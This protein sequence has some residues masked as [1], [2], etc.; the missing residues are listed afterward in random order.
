MKWHNLALIFLVGLL[1]IF[2]IFRLAKDDDSHK[3]KIRERVA[4]FNAQTPTSACRSAQLSRN[5]DQNFMNSCATYSSICSNP[6]TLTIVDNL[7]EGQED[8]YMAS[9]AYAVGIKP[10]DCGKL[11]Y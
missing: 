4:N 9:Y 11:L 2:L 1:C 10:S 3:R 6:D 7:P 8:S 5:L